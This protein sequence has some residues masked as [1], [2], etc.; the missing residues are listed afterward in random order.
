MFETHYFWFILAAGLVILEL[1][2]GTFY[3]L[4]LAV[5][6][7][8][9][10]IAAWLGTGISIQ[11]VVTAA[12]TIAGWALLRKRQIRNNKGLPDVDADSAV[13]FDIGE[14]VHVV[15][16]SPEGQATVTH[17][18]CQWQ[19]ELAKGAKAM[20]GVFTVVKVNGNKLVLRHID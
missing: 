20:P 2:T 9:G 14:K 19:A 10:G 5:G 6:C 18:G 7:A 17:R 4:V 13:H 8:G 12:V 16:W 11:L 3:L 15:S 1:L